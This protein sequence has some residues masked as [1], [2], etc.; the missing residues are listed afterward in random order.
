MTTI[1]EAAQALDIT[2]QAAAALR[3]QIADDAGLYNAETLEI[4]DTGMDVLR[5]VL[6]KNSDPVA[7]DLLAEVE[8]LGKAHRE[9]LGE[10]DET[11]AARDAAIRKAVQFGHN[12][13]RVAELAGISR[14]R[15]YQIIA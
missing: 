5:T 9:K 1:R 14:E 7:A 13:T 10:A 6:R 11:Q 8:Y 15:L 4:T 3:D 2:E 12:R